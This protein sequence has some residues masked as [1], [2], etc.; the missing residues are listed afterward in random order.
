[1]NNSERTVRLFLVGI[2][3]GCFSDAVFPQA[4]IDQRLED[5]RGG[6]GKWRLLTRFIFYCF[7]RVVGND[8]IDYTRRQGNRNIKHKL[9]VFIDTC[10][11]FNNHCKAFPRQF[12]FMYC[13]LKTILQKSGVG[14]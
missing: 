1:M 13:T 6:S 3:E 7:C 11:K 4:C 10:P 9:A 5:R 14:G 2:E 12:I 8:N